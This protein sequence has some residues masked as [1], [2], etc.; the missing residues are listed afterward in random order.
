MEPR[1]SGCKASVFSLSNLWP[2][3]LIKDNIYL[4]LWFQRA[5]IHDRHDKEHVPDRKAYNWSSTRELTS[6][7]QVHGRNRET[8]EFNILFNVCLGYESCYQKGCYGA[9]CNCHPWG[10]QKV[11]SSYIAILR[12][13]WAIWDLMSNKQGERCFWVPIMLELQI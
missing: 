11:I 5:I 9:P 7:P 8:P 13:A 6:D 1:F 12:P 3:Q 2:R 4:G 10:W